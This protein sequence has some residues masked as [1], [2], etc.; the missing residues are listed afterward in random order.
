MPLSPGTTFAG[1][2]IRQLLGAGGMGEVYLAE[3]PRLPRRD[4]LKILR[5]E[6]SSDVDFRE[7]FRREADLAAALSH[8]HIVSVYDRGECNDQLWIATAYVDGADAAQLLRS[9]YPAGM[10]ALEAS[11]IITAIASALDYAHDQGLLH[12]D[13]KPAN[14]LLSKSDREGMRNVYLAD[15]GIA[16]PLADPNGLTATNLTV[17]TVAY[18]A[19]EQLMGEAI[20]GRADQYALAATA[21]DLLTGAP[22]YVESNPVAVISRHLS[23]PPPAISNRRPDLASFEP[24]FARAL[25][26]NPDERF[27]SCGGFAKALAELTTAGNDQKVT[28]A[29]ITTKGPAIR[30]RGCGEVKV[31]ATR[32]G[33]SVVMA[34]V[35]AAITAGLVVSGV[36]YFQSRQ[37]D[38]PAIAQAPPYEGTYRTVYDDTK[39][40]TNGLPDVA[41]GAG[42]TIVFGAY[43]SECRTDGCVASGV[44]LNPENP[45]VLRDPPIAGFRYYVDGAWLDQFDSV[46]VPLPRCLESGGLTGPGTSKV[47]P[48]IRAEPQSDGTLRGV[49]YTTVLTN[50][51]GLQGTVFETPFIS[52]RTGEVPPGV[53]VPDPASAPPR[54]TALASPPDAPVLEGLYR[55]DISGEMTENGAPFNYG[56][57][58]TTG[59]WS[60]RSLCSP[61]SCIATASRVSELDHGAPAGF[62]MVLEFRDG[63]WTQPPELINEIRC[64]PV[65]TNTATRVLS[66]KPQPDGTLQGVSTLEMVGANQCTRK[67]AIF[68]AEAKATKVGDSPPGVTVADPALFMGE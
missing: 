68:R 60:F 43:R 18:A 24:V 67:G 7:R 49:R 45:Q 48:T 63:A 35:A 50:E 12:R 53:E 52:T 46:Q 57:A 5:S 10:P 65:G 58:G 62:A 30:D 23:A 61:T 37:S 11:A 29:S 55:I 17:G 20:D 27:G 40:R 51:C 34:A 32:R 25:A 21:F 47:V 8:P 39:Q 42:Q 56:G 31:K 4:A 2:T 9:R 16:R 36:H 64:E 14:I 19:P 22:P 6:V 33:R 15:F 26:K 28:A 44:G 41:V 3:H 1:Y 38:P 13:V 66:L 59:W 54:S